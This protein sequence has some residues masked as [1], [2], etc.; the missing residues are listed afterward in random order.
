MTACWPAAGSCVNCR[1]RPC[2]G[3]LAR[4]LGI[5]MLDGRKAPGSPLASARTAL[6]T[7]SRTRSCSGWVISDGV[8]AEHGHVAVEGFQRPHSL[9]GFRAGPPG[10]PDV[11]GGE[12]QVGRARAGVTAR[13]LILPRSWLYLD[14]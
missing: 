4:G 6:A 8:G 13:S 9:R 11:Q 14:S 1:S 5:K 2:L 12:V 3:S 7:S 10:Q